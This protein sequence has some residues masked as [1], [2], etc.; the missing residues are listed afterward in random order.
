MIGRAAARA[1]AE[2]GWQVVAVSRSGGL[3]DGL[4]ELGVQAVAADRADDAQLRAAVGADADVL[5]DTVAFTREHGEQLNALAGLARRH[6]ERVGLCRRRG[7]GAGRRERLSGST[8]PDSGDAA[9]G[10]ARRRQLLDA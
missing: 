9:D 2:D 7:Q 8:R 10:G 1:F 4:E 3:P 5:V 6:L